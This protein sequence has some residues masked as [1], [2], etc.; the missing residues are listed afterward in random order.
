M[1]F[2]QRDFSG[3]LF[4][5]EKENERQPDY[6][7]PA[8]IDGVN[9]YVSGFIKNKASDPNYDPSKKTFMGLSFQSKRQSA[10]TEG[11][12]NYKLDKNKVH[13]PPPPPGVAQPKSE[14]QDLDH[15]APDIDPDF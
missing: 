3:A 10:P 12:R 1:S 13:R 5:T 11:K 7:G 14:P 4:K 2:T 8:M 15:N 9:Y 6:S